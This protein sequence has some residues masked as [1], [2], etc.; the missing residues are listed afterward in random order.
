[1]ERFCI[2]RIISLMTETEVLF[3]LLSCKCQVQLLLEMAE[4]VSKLESKA[5]RE[6]SLKAMLGLSN[7][8]YK[9]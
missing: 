8:P 7:N 9:Q 4:G 5:E 2:A 3:P 6:L 1:M